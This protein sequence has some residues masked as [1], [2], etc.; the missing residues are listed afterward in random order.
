MLLMRRFLAF[1]VLCALGCGGDTKSKPVTD[2]NKD[3][4]P[5][6][7]G[8][9]SGKKAAGGGSSPNAVEK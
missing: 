3:L 4:P 2:K 5:A 9:G 1:G 8:A 6:P 7:M